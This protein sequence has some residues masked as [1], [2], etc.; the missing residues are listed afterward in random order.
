[1]YGVMQV[2]LLALYHGRILHVF[3]DSGGTPLFGACGVGFKDLRS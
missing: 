1:M 3:L 2:R